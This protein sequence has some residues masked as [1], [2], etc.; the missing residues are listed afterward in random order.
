[1]KDRLAK[2]QPSIQN[3]AR[4]ILVVLFLVR[5][6]SY[7]QNEWP[8]ERWTEVCGTINGQKLGTFVAGVPPNPNLLYRA[9]VSRSGSTSF[10][11]LQSPSDTSAQLTIPDEN[12]LFGDLNS[13]GWLD[14]VTVKS[15]SNGND[16]LCVF[17]G[18]AKGLELTNP[19]LI[20]N[21]NRYDALRGKFIGDINN[22]GRADLILGA[23]SYPNLQ[24]KGKVYIFLHPVAS[25]RPDMT[26]VGDSIG[27]FLGAACLVG[28]LNND[29]IMDLVIKG[30]N[31]AGPTQTRYDYVRIYWGKSK[32]KL[33]L[34]LGT[35]L[36]GYNLSNPGLGCFDANGDGTDDLLWTNR[37]AGSDWIYVHYG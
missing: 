31:Q 8:L 17:W 20:P 13:D 27:Y 34:E 7:A 12:P 37:D 3:I 4:K 21:E 18:R 36:R 1:M 10:F 33:D 14:V 32:A 15:S 9:A 5:S 28:D 35:E 26:F 25:E 23:E 24:S 19:L 2:Q 29:G 22:D 11:R 6:F 16:T 30:S